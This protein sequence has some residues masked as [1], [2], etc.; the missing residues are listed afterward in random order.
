MKF[1]LQPKT[2]AVN[3]LDGQTISV[4]LA[5][6]PRLVHASSEERD[7]WRLIGMGE[8]IHWPDLYE[9]IDVKGLITAR[10]PGESPEPLA[11]WLKG[12]E[13]LGRSA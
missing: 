1:L 10:A 7:S 5:W 8:G 2:L 11:T 3:L 4:P 13:G 12:R 9:D 6:F